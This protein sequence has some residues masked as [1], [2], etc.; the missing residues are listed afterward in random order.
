[1]V[2]SGTVVD[3]LLAPL[4]GAT[5]R[6]SG[7]STTTNAMGQF[8][9]SGVPTPYDAVILTTQSTGR[10]HGYVF[11]DLTR[12][13][14]TFQLTFD[15][16]PAISAAMVTGMTAT[17]TFDNPAGIVFADLAS[18]DLAAGS[19]YVV[20]AGGA[21]S[22]AANI[23]WIGPAPA[24]AT[25]YDLQWLQPADGGLPGT[26]IGFSQQMFSL[27]PGGSVNWAVSPSVGPTL[28]IMPVTVTTSSGYAVAEVALY[29]RPGGANVAAPIARDGSHQNSVTFT[30]PEIP[31]A[32]FAVC[33]VQAPGGTTSATPPFGVDCQTN[34]LATQAAGL[35][36][37]PAPLLINPPTAAGPGTVFSW[38]P[39]S[40]GISLIAFEPTDST[41]VTSPG[42]YVV[43]PAASAGLPDLGAFGLP[44]KSGTA[45]TAAVYSFAPFPHLDGAAGPSG[46]S[47]LATT[48]GLGR[49][50]SAA[51][52]LGFSGANLFT[53]Q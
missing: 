19:N 27:S 28:T 31:G 52:Q 15:V 53:S 10:K 13:D 32:T 45:Y 48:V 3:S 25:L 30:T 33:G 26:Y 34:L 21:Q 42:L 44:L 24:Q 37:P 1:M 14:P 7:A 46:F 9:L 4:S 2:L 39:P 50:P 36:P 17:G 23:G 20:L 41:A 18:P 6:I 16:S 8:T 11:G 47:S 29:L 49:G 35:V 5:V 22:F 51:G 12:S 43:T 40:G 38:N